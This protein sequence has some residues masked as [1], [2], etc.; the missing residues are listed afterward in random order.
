MSQELSIEQNSFEIAIQQYQM[1]EN[2]QLFWWS[3]RTITKAYWRMQEKKVNE[4][5]KPVQQDYDSATFCTKLFPCCMR[6]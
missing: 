1:A 6:C 5:Q 3:L 2:V 4:R